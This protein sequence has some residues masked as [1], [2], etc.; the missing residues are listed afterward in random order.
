[1]RTRTKATLATAGGLLAL[2]IGWGVYSSRRTARVPYETVER[3]DD[4]EIRRYP[5]TI[6]VE[7]T[8]P[9]RRTAFR[10]LFQ[11]ISGANEGSESV[12]MTAPVAVRDV[13]R[14][15]SASEQPLR[16]GSARVP[17]TSPVRTAT[18]GETVTMAF[19][20][21]SEYTPETAPTPT[22]PAVRLVVEPA[23][24]VAAAQFSWY[25]TEN[26]VDRHRRRLLDELIAHDVEPVG[27]P[28]LLQYNDPWTPPFMRR[29]E[30]EVP[31]EEQATTIPID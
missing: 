13:R 30:V 22:D 16:A 17:M 1:M 29:N 18:D 11:Y 3:F 28:T 25:A 31:V 24:T 2:W 26:R 7:T 15:V 14:A 6:F 27:E 4:V 12:A 8:A 20:L 23:R 19:Y 21:P 10:R 9:D 5:R